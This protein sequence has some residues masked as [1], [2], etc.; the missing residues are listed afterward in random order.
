MKQKTSELVKQIRQL[1]Y[2]EDRMEVLKDTFKDETVYIIG[3]GPSLNTHPVD[4]IKDKLQNELVFCIKQSYHTFNEICDFQ[5]INFTN[6][7]PYQINPNHIAAWCYFHPQHPQMIIQNGWKVDLLYP[8]YGDGNDWKERGYEDKL[9]QS[10]FAE[11]RFEDFSFE[12]SIE[13]PWGPGITYELAIPLA[14]HLGVKKIVTIGW[15]IGTLSLYDDNLKDDIEGLNQNKVWQDHSYDVDKTQMLDKFNMT[16]REVS[17]VAN[18]FE[19]MYNW[20][21][22]QGVEFNIIS[23]RNPASDIIPRVE[24]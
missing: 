13:R 2:V 17:L 20:I 3:A 10:V 23:D 4:K 24:L 1:E 21:T 7:S 14:I 18:K 22:S 9:G 19:G 8:M 5:L 15:D 6:L 16:K 11:D 12:K